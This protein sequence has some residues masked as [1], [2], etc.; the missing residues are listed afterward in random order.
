MYTKDRNMN[1]NYTPINFTPDF[2]AKVQQ[3]TELMQTPEMIN[4]T[5]NK[6]EEQIFGNL[7]EP[8]TDIP[9]RNPN[10]KMESLLEE[11]LKQYEST[12]KDLHKQLEEAKLQLKQLNDKESSQNLY[13]KELKAD[14]QMESL[15]RELAENKLSSKDWKV[16][17][18]AGV[19]GLITGLICAW[20]G[21][22]LQ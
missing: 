15:K 21:V 2:E 19:I 16:A 9:F 11:Q 14:L 18:I 7:S 3:F 1:N 6:A 10:E 4:Y 22:I 17:L 5:A 13:I 20:A 12:N 8:L